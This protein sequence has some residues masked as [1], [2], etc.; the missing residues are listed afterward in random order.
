ML[1]CEH[2]INVSELMEWD[3]TTCDGW[4]STKRQ[5]PSVEN[6]ICCDADQGMRSVWHGH[7]DVL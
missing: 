2:N 1:L 4:T 3:W 6:S 7:E 5:V